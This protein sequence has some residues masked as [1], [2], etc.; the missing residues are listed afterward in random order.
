MGGLNIPPCCPLCNVDVESIIHSLRDCRHALDFW[1]SFAL[2]IQSNL[3]YS[4]N[5]LVWLQINCTSHLHSSMGIP[6]STLFTFGVWC[7]WLRCNN[8]IFKN[9]HIIKPLMAKTIAKA[10]EFAFLGVN[11]R[12]CRSLTTI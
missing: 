3:F 12:H 2:P 6:W 5:L 7:L 10:L 8:F 9:Q 1:N 11:E 4:A